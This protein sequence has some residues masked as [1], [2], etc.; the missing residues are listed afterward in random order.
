MSLI[1]GKVVL[2]IYVSSD[3]RITD[4]VWM[5]EIFGKTTDNGSTRS[6]MVSIRNATVTILSYGRLVTVQ[7][8]RIEFN[9]LELNVTNG[10]YVC[11]IRNEHGLKEASI[12]I[13]EITSLLDSHERPPKRNTT[14]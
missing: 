5:R 8:Q 3:P 2:S 7:G 6:S 4:I 11:Q 12:N 13:A 9:I 14:G 1:N 10:R